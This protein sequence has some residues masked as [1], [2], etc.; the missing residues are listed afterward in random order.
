M[1][2]DALRVNWEMFAETRPSDR[3]S[4]TRPRRLQATESLLERERSSAGRAAR[5]PA[6]RGR[7]AWLLADPGETVPVLTRPRG[8]C[9]WGAVGSAMRVCRGKA[10]DATSPFLINDFW[11]CLELSSAYPE[12]SGIGAREL[13]PGLVNR[14]T[15]EV[16]SEENTRGIPVVQ[17]GIA[18]IGV[19]SNEEAFDEDELRKRG[20]HKLDEELTPLL[21]SVLFNSTGD[22]TSTEGY[23]EV[24]SP[25]DSP[26][27]TQRMVDWWSGATSWFSDA[28]SM[29]LLLEV[30]LARGCLSL[31]L[32]SWSKEPLVI[33]V[34]GML[35]DKGSQRPWMPIVQLPAVGQQARIIDLHVVSDG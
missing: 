21:S 32:G 12:C 33:R 16:S 13:Q 25:G 28:L 34:P 9:K 1:A 31:R 18:R 8:G 10:S 7:R 5:H 6:E 15:Y 27:L 20:A 19:P 22:F 17:V 29:Q 11:D 35:E 23:I 26:A 3:T 2:A 14:I 24:L 30:D 4:L